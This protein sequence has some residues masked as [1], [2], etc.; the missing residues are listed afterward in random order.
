MNYILFQ[1]YD[2]WADGFDSDGYDMDIDMMDFVKRS[3]EKSV[4]DINGLRGYDTQYDSAKRAPKNYVFGH[5]SDGY[6]FVKRS[7]KHDVFGYGPDGYMYDFVKRAPINDVF[8]YGSDGYLYD[9]VR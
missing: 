4:S 3:Q 6:D 8:G 7:P 1:K 5:G 2:V 9:F